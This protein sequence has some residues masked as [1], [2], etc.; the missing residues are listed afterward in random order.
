MKTNF[1]LG[2]GMIALI[3]FFL[4]VA[5]NY[6]EKSICHTE[7]CT[8]SEGSY[9]ICVESECDE[10]KQKIKCESTRSKEMVCSKAYDLQRYLMSHPTKRDGQRAP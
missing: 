7:L 2:F 3:L 4:A 6:S 9:H 10:L 8:D 1:N 5:N